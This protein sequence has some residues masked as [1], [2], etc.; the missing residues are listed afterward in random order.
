MQQARHHSE[1]QKRAKREGHSFLAVGILT[2]PC[3]CNITKSPSVIFIDLPKAAGLETRGIWI[4]K[5][6]GIKRVI[7]SQTWS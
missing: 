3:L 6:G 5:V 4:H 1:T 2:F 7:N